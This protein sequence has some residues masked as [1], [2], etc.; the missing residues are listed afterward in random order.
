MVELLFLLPQEWLTQTK[1]QARSDIVVAI[2]GDGSL[3]EGMSF[4]GLNYAAQEKLP[5]IIV[6]N[7]NG[8]AIA[9]NVGGIKNL[10][11]GNNWIKKSKA[12]V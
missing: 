4:E 8:M 2:I 12:L 11:S 5:L 3:V 1:C 10:F 7:D 6:I 9:P